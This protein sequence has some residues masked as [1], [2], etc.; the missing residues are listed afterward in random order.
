MLLGASVRTYP[1]YLIP[2]LCFFR[3]RVTLRFSAE[4]SCTLNGKETKSVSPSP[5]HHVKE[6]ENKKPHPSFTRRMQIIIVNVGFLNYEDIETHL[7]CRYIVIG[8]QHIF[9]AI[10]FPSP[11][12]HRMR[13][14]LHIL[15]SFVCCLGRR[16]WQ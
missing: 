8:V 12:S 10:P 1:L 13:V 9:L 3:H 15:S 11:L 4:S 14:F 2:Y 16:S 5:S 7:L 6:I